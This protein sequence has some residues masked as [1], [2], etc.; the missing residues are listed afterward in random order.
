M[1]VQIQPCGKACLRL[2]PVTRAWLAMVGE[3]QLRAADQ[4]QRRALYRGKP[5][6]GLN[7]G[8]PVRGTDRLCDCKRAGGEIRLFGQRFHRRFH[9]LGLCKRLALRLD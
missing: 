4:A 3:P 9:P 1:H 2:D 5:L 7:C 8:D 6:T